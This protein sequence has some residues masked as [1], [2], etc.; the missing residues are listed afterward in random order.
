MIWGLGKAF[1]FPGIGIE[2]YATIIT[3]L[4]DI[5]VLTE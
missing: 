2:S 4:E 5:Y 1:Y 3:S